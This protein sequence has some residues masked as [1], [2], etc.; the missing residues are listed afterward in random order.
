[1]GDKEEKLIESFLK[2]MA[3]LQEFADN[4][5]IPIREVPVGND[6]NPYLIDCIIVR[7]DHVKEELFKLHAAQKHGIVKRYGRIR[8]AKDPIKANLKAGAEI[9]L[10]EAKTSKEKL[11]EAIGQI[12]VY[13]ELFLLDYPSTRINGTIIILPKITVDSNINNGIERLAQK[14]GTIIKLI[15]LRYNKFVR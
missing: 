8:N 9:W 10:L 15:P 3:N 13:R 6:K 7:K 5:W 4:E 12:L 2:Y 11:W 1:M 14:I